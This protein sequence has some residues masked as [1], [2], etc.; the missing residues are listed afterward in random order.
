MAQN[1]N[2][3]SGLFDYL[4]W[5]GDLSF[6]NVPVGE[7]DSLI[8]SGLSY[9][10]FSDSVGEEPSKK[11][12]VLLNATKSYLKAQSGIIKSM[13]LIIPRELITMLVRTS[14][15]ARFGL[16]RP[17]CHVNRVCD[18]EQIQF[19]ATSF[20]LPGGS[21]FV[22]FRG[23]DDT[24]VGWKENFNM[25]FMQPV[26]AQSEALKY[27]EKI[28][29][30]TEGRLYVG[31]HSKG[32]NLAV[33]ASVKAS[34]S[35]KSRISAVY[36]HDGPGFDRDFI[37]SADY[38][39]M[40]D[41]IFTLVPQTSVVGMMLEHE[42]RYTV[43]KSSS[44]GLLQHNPLSWAVMGGSFIK[45]DSIDEESRLIDSSLKAWLAEISPEERERFVDELY[46]A[47]VSTN[48][49]T[50]SDLNADKIKIVKAWSAM[51]N[52]LRSI[53][54][55]SLNIIVGKKNIKQQKITENEEE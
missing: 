26:P 37:E 45:L 3:T 31:G 22:A 7:V 27:L 4:N 25:S 49:K 10:D 15:T 18:R 36:N 8:F 43:V 34:E 44:A 29:S 53:L 14:K 55:K 42:E 32:G 13:G 19:S 23:T 33:Y 54:I 47:L 39:K 48:A 12:A 21:T 9:I 1:A 46:E 52:E 11:P 51:D 20:M 16:T 35:T 6:E 30:L 17:F 5:R 40:R 24:L 28:A 38:D 41:R 50:L 2:Q